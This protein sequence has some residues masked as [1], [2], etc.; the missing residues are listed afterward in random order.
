MKLNTDLQK[1]L[2]D[3]GEA[4]F[5][6]TL[7]TIAGLLTYEFCLMIHLDIFGWN[8]GLVFSPLVAGYVETYFAQKYMKE[9]TGAV[10]AFILFAVTVVYGF[11]IANPT[12]GFN[13]ITIGSVIVILQAAIPTLINYFII[14][15]ILAMISYI[16]GIF[17]KITGFL[18]KIYIKI[19]SKITGEE[20]PIIKP[21][22]NINNFDENLQI[23]INDLGILL[24]STTHLWNQE[25]IK[26]N[27][28]YE[29]KIIYKAKRPMG[30]DKEE[31]LL[32]KDLRKIKDQAIAN[33]CKEAKN[34]GCNGILDLTL[35][36][37]ILDGNGTICNVTAHGT[38]VVI[39]KSKTW[40]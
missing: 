20:L 38:G 7:G 23:D 26:Y 2:D 9:T 17:K 1:R 8:L 33:L 19:K 18:Y 5:C 25:V 15:I 24:L 10:S 3:F 37:D 40:S 31:E 34:D 16:S 12:L 30:F 22:K 28:I 21:D 27:G 35:E 36:Y 29:G 6:I 32:L 11:I 39:E 14:I 4:T 13:F